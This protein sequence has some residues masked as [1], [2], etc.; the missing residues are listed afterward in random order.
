VCRTEASASSGGDAHEDMVEGKEEV[1]E[2]V[3]DGCISE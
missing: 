1:E 2:V 3:Q